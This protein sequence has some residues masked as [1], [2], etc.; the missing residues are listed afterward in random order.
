LLTFAPYSF[1]SLSPFVLSFT[2]FP[3]QCSPLSNSAGIEQAFASA[4]RYRRESPGTVVVVL[5]DEVGLA[6]QSPHLPLKVLHKLLDEAG[7]NESVVGI[8]NWTLDPAKMN[9]AVHLYRP[10][11]T[12]EDLALTAEGMVKSANLKGYLGA[13]AKAYSAVYHAQSHA[14]FW[15]LREYYST[16]RA[17]NAAINQP[18]TTFHEGEGGGTGQAMA[19]SLSAKHPDGNLASALDAS[20]LLNAVLRN[21]GGRPAEMEAIVS[22]FFDEL[23]LPLPSVASWPWAETLVRA[24]LREPSA[25]HLMLLTKNNGALPLVFD[26]GTL[27]HHTTEVIFGS[28]FPLDQTDLQIVL[29]IQRVKL[30]MAAGTTVVLVHCESLYESLY[31]MTGLR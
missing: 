10:A 24:N 30:C 23:R 8:S 20:M 14:D 11:P 13:L 3:Y 21:F 2:V 28:D 26:R 25:R 4:Q 12:V 7:D 15:G 22:V 27:S 5:L 31:G 9:R 16:V 18:S 1:L 29:D 17:I 19:S 6:E